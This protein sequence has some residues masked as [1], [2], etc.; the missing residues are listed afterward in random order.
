MANTLFECYISI[1]DGFL[2]RYVCAELKFDHLGVVY[3][4]SKINCSCLVYISKCV[5][6]K[7]CLVVKDAMP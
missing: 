7:A 3:S 1:I 5:H 2:S 6:A 4:L